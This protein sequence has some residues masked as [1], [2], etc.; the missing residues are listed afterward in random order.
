[1]ESLS[2]REKVGD[3]VIQRYQR[4]SRMESTAVAIEAVGSMRLATRRFVMHSC[5]ITAERRG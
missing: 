1:M 3:S 5:R 2:D 4:P